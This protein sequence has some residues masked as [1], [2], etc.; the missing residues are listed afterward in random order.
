MLLRLRST[1]SAADREALLRLAGER[2]FEGRFLGRAQ[3]L[4]E[5]ERR[6]GRPQAGDRAAF[7]DLA[8]V[9][10]VLEAADAPELTERVAGREDTQ[11]RVGE[12]LFGGNSLALIAG[13]CAIEDEERLVEIARGVRAAGATA[14]RGG[15]YKPRTSPYSFAGCGEAGLAWLARAGAEVSLPVVTEVLDPRDVETVARVADVL[16]IGARSMSNF[17]LLAEVARTGKV[18]LLKRGPAAT[19]REFLLAAEHV[20]ARGNARVILCERGVRGFDRV[21][22]NLLDVGAV[23]YLKRVTH[24]PV[25]VDPSHAAG[26]SDLVVPLARAGLAAGADGLIVEVHSA[27]GETRSDGAQALDLESFAG[28]ARTAAALARLDGRRLALPADHHRAPAR[29]GEGVHP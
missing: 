1:A 7:E 17:A 8:A 9:A 18:V 15:A 10:G 16:Q 3:S 5:L 24:L 11:I 20:L 21:T 12:A 29:A 19:V 14:L 2:G 26:R 27:P 28:L 23:A 6:S 25:I 13:P 4:L 22:R